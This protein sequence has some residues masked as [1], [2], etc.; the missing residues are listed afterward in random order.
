MNTNKNL[1]EMTAAYCTLL[2][3]AKDP[4]VDPQIIEDTMEALEG[5]IEEK[6]ENYAS[7][8]DNLKIEIAGID[9]EINQVKTFLDGMQSKKKALENNMERLRNNLRDSMTATGKT[10]FKAGRRSFWLKENEE[11]ITDEKDMSKI[12]ERFI[13]YGKPEYNKTAMKEAIKKG[14]DLKGIAHIQINTSLQ[15]R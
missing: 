1:F 8:I 9:G 4:E 14:E 15:Y 3:M 5:E 7:V 2:D 13:R 12:P 6:A 10:K 11:V